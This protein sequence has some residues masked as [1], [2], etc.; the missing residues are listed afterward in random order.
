VKRLE[1]DDAIAKVKA[2]AVLL[3]V[4]LPSEHENESLPDSVNIPLVYLRRKMNTLDKTRAYVIYCDTGRR[5]SS[6]AFLMSERDFDV[7]VLN[8]GMNGRSPADAA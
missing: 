3:D 7:Y 5:S 4:R 8:E 2:G 6:A 1:Y